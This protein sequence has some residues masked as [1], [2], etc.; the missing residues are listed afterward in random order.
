MSVP[1]CGGPWELCCV[2]IPALGGPLGCPE[3][4]IVATLSVAELMMRW[5][6]VASSVDSTIQ[7]IAGA[8]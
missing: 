6:D 3:V 5:M 8:S 2:L 4:D 1:D 7:K